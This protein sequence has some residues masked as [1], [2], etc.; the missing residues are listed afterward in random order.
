M[1]WAGGLVGVVLGMEC[2]RLLGGFW[3]LA[4]WALPFVGFGVGFLVGLLLAGVWVSGMCSW[5]WML[6]VFFGRGHYFWEA[7]AFA[8]CGLFAQLCFGCS[9]LRSVLRCMVC[10]GGGPVR[11]DSS[12]RV[13]VLL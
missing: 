10:C 13:W 1:V 5:I 3:F 7:G 4:L 9:L 12:C 8:K 6:W 11:C 2:S